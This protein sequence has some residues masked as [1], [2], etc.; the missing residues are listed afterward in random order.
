MNV[1]H[2]AGCEV[3]MSGV[4]GILGRRSAVTNWL[5]EFRVGGKSSRARRT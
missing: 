5:D 1:L 3:V 2:P 4:E